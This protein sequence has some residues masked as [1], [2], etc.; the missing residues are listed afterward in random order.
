M[1]KIYTKD[2]SDKK[3]LQVASSFFIKIMATS[4]SWPEEKERSISKKWCSR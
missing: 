4:F 3:K 2:T 1:H